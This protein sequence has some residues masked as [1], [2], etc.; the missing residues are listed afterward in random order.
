MVNILLGF[1][2]A[3]NAIL[4]FLIYAAWRFQKKLAKQNEK[5]VRNYFM[6][7]FNKRAQA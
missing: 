1:S 3:L 6:Q 2:L 7:I 4:F 5:I